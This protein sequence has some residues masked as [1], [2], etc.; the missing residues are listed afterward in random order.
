MGGVSRRDARLTALRA[1]LEQRVSTIDLPRDMPS[2]AALVPEPKTGAL[3]FERFPFQRE[4]YAQA[5][6]DRELV[7][8]KGTQLGISTWALRWILFHA[9]LH[10]RT[11]LYVFP[12]KADVLD[13]SAA[14]IKR[15][16]GASEYLRGRH[17]AGGPYA[18]GLIAVGRGI[19]YF[20][21]SEAERGL[22]SVDADVLVLDEYDTLN[23]QNVPDAERRI[24]SP[25][26][27]GLI[28]RVGV[29][30]AP[31]VG[32][33]ALYE[34]SDQ[35]RWHVRCAGCGEWQA[36]TFFENVDL[37]RARV[38]CRSCR[39]PLDVARGEWVAE[40]PDRAVRGY[41][42]AQLI[43]PGA[44]LT[45]LV[46]ASKKSPAFE[47][48][49]FF[50]KDLG[51]P[52][53]PEGGRL[54]LA[55]LQA[56]QSAGNFTMVDSYTSDGL[57]TMGVDV[58]ST[59]DLHVRISEHLSDGTRRGIY[60][61][62]VSG[63]DELDELMAHFRVHLAAIDHMPE[64]RLARAFAERHHG[65]V[66]LVAYDPTARPRSDDWIRVDEDARFV[67]V[68]RLEA[69]DEMMAAFRAQRNLLPLDLPDQYVAHLRSL[70]RVRTADPFGNERVVYQA[71][72]PDDFAH[73]ETYD[74]VAGLLWRIRRLA[75][76]LSRETVVQL[77]DVVDFKRSNLGD[78]S[79]ELEYDTG[80]DYDDEFREW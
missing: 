45:R 8:M 28:R 75:E 15:V 44:D 19:V 56:A 40:F 54:S 10:G 59:R 62:T 67:T 47:R 22:D 34:Q 79:A 25:T 80:P 69:I 1:M 61:S 31:S 20:R 24:T 12:T 72:G 43:V 38:V 49:R 17:P 39:K 26:S 33:A 11:G 7:V 6:D 36:P 4:L 60:I 3:D 53:E 23:Q 30:S 64:R 48:E 42:V 68:R 29:P 55:V 63:F 5:I 21:G 51:L 9:D 46:A 37:E 52:Y 58:A 78:Y 18:R 77:D 16:I 70:V 13:F 32:I 41:Q 71:T 76:D 73:A 14:R 2:W 66:Y 50:R 27:A 57:V 35:R 74:L 65:R